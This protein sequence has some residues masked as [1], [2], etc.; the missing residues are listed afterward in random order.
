MILNVILIRPLDSWVKDKGFS[1]VQSVHNS[2]QIMGLIDHDRNV[3]LAWNSL[4]EL[5]RHE[6]STVCI[7]THNWFVATPLLLVPRILVLRLRILLLW[8]YESRT[9]F[10]DAPCQ[11]SGL[12]RTWTYRNTWI[13]ESTRST[14]G[15]YAKPA[16]PSLIGAI[17]GD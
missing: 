10:F 3:T 7:R 14:C 8:R 9:L 6:R 16:I 2:T 15:Q 11:V 4:S 13:L 5:P 12:V 17:A 1:L